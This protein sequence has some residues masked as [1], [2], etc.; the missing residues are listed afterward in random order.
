MLA[1]TSFGAVVISG[2]TTIGNTVGDVIL[3]T[4]STTRFVR[5]DWRILLAESTVTHGKIELGYDDRDDGSGMVIADG[6][7]LNSSLAMGVGGSSDIYLTLDGTL[8]GATVSM[9]GINTISSIINV[10]STGVMS[11]TGNFS[12]RSKADMV[13]NIDGGSVTFGGLDLEAAGSSLATINMM[14]GGTMTIAGDY[15]TILNNLAN[16]TGDASIVYNAGTDNTIV[17]AIPEPATLGLI[18]AFGAGILFVRRRL[19]I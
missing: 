16:L 14:N 10:S 9:G 7:T 1:S 17:T 3:D 19:M 12:S 13:L 5:G 11:L 8:N 15:V 6:Q 4:T 2:D 18:S